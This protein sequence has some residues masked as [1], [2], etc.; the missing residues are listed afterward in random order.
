[1]CPSSICQTCVPCLL[2]NHQANQM[3]GKARRTMQCQPGSWSWSWSLVERATLWHNI[4]EQGV[5][6]HTKNKKQKKTQ[7]NSY[8]PMFGGLASQCTFSV[9]W[10]DATPL[11]GGGGGRGGRGA[12]EEGEGGREWRVGGGMEGRGGGWWCL[13]SLGGPLEEGLKFP[14][15]SCRDN[16]AV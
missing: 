13:F 1:M 7:K 9:H 3:D 16:T 5:M 2:P 10:R 15:G 14:H 6:T 11:Q 8:V 12:G 4:D